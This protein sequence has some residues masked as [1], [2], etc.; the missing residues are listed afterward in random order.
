MAKQ[1][2]WVRLTEAD[3][4]QTLWCINTG[5]KRALAVYKR[6]VARANAGDEVEWGKG[7]A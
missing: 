6:E 3:G 4:T 5:H 1:A 7:E 2:Y